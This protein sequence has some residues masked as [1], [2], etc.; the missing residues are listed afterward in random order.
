MLELTDPEKVM[1]QLDLYWIDH[2]GKNVLDYFEKYPGR[3]ELWHIKDKEEVGAS[4]IMD[5][6]AI[7]VKE[8]KPVQNMVL[9]KSRNIILPR[10]KVAKRAWSI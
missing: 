4:G 3:F 2:G 5:F 9:L 8:N 7:F 1:F 10:L 6:D